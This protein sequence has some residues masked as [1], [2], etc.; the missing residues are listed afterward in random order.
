MQLRCSSPDTVPHTCRQHIWSRSG[1]TAGSASPAVIAPDV[2][3][4]LE[5]VSYT[6]RWE[7]DGEFD[8]SVAPMVQTSAVAKDH[9]DGAGLRLWLMRRIYGGPRHSAWTFA[10]LCHTPQRRWQTERPRLAFRF[11]VPL[12]DCRQ[13]KGPDTCASGRW[14]CYG[15]PTQPMCIGISEGER[16][17]LFQTRFTRTRRRTTR[18]VGHRKREQRARTS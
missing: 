2:L 12:G 10:R 17:D 7:S 11:P 3:E 13:D 6:G 15:C 4:E 5:R 16:G 9:S 14:I 18:R 1:R 8:R